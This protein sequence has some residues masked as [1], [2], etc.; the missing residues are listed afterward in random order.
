MVDYV[1]KD[2]QHGA[3]LKKNFKKLEFDENLKGS[4]KRWK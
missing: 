3:K 1:Y 4:L 2:S